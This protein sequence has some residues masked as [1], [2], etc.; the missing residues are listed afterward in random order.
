MILRC[1][2]A[3]KKNLNLFSVFF[4]SYFFVSHTKIPFRFGAKEAKQTLFFRYFASL[5][6]LP[7]RFVSLRSEIRGHPIRKADSDV[8]AK[9]V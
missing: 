7:F 5:M 9:V 6:L 4:A 2:S 1:N 3:L 8:Q